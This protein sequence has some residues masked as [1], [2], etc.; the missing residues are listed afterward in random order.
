MQHTCCFALLLV[1]W[2]LLGR[3]CHLKVIVRVVRLKAVLKASRSSLQRQA[4]ASGIAHGSLTKHRELKA[5]TQQVSP[6]I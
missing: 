4:D 5:G 1:G 6:V 3:R 2:R